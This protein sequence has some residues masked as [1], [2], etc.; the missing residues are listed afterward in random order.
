MRLD[1]YISKAL[2]VTR[3]EAKQ[4]IKNGE[5]TVDGKVIKKADFKVPEG[6]EVLVEGQKV[7]AKD[8]VYIMLNKPK[9]YLSTTE[10]NRDYPSFL[11]LLPEYEHL[12]P[13]AAGRLDVDA[14]GFLLVTNDGEL[15]HRI[16]HPKWK[17]PKTYKV[18]LERPLSGEDIRRIQNKE[19]VIEGKPV[20]VEKIEVLEPN[21]VLLTITEG[22]FHIVKR[23]FEA[24][25]NNV[26]N[27]KRVAIGNIKLDSELLEGYYRELTEEEVEELKKS[28]KM[29][30]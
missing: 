13:F 11:D 26:L 30:D 27:L 14:E 28:V 29:K 21:R 2:G 4:I 25:N 3:K 5:V 7:E 23:L 18:I 8:K 22:R 17:V 12:K 24:L 9:G 15:A 1:K 20:Q 6:A 19:I 16:T 10:R